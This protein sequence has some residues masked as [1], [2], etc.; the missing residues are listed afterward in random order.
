[1][2]FNN[3][4]EINKLH[5]LLPKGNDLH[6]FCIPLNRLKSLVLFTT[7]GLNINELMMIIVDDD[8]WYK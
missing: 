1:M 7:V 3:D 6:Y 2:L 5:R 8:R 4:Q